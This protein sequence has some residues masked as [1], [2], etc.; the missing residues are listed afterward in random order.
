[1]VKQSSH[2]SAEASHKLSSRWGATAS[3]IPLAGLW[4]SC[5]LPCRDKETRLTHK[6]I[7]SWVSHGLG[8]VEKVPNTVILSEAK[9]LLPLLLINLQILRL[10]S[11]S[12]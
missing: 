6:L 11:G 3:K 4:D 8:T 12:E 1:M 10:R 9:D 2:K 5:R 7:L